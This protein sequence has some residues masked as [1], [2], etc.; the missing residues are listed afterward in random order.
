MDHQPNPPTGI[1]P[2]VGHQ[3]SNSGSS[4]QFTL[5]KQWIVSLVIVDCQ[6]NPTTGIPYCGLSASPQAYPIVGRQ[7]LHKHTL[8]WVVSLSTGI[9]YCGSST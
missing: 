6:P 5:K 9:P 3:P 8:L 4:G 7:P 1:K 2:I